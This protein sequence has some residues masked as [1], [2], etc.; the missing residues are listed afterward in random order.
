MVE[1]KHKLIKGKVQQVIFKTDLL[2]VLFIIQMNLNNKLWWT[3]LP[4]LVYF[5]ITFCDLFYIYTIKVL[6]VVDGL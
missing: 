3:L 5:S 2:I 4:Q 6:D 1:G